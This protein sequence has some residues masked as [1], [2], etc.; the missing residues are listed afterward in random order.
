MALLTVSLA[1][2][3]NLGPFLAA[4]EG[5]ATGAVRTVLR[6]QGNKARNHLRKQIRTAGLGKLDKTVRLSVGPPGQTLP[7]DL[8]A[9]VFSSS[10]IP[11]QGQPVNLLAVYAFGTTIRPTQ[12]QRLAIPT[13]LAPRSGR[14]ALSPEEAG[15]GRFVLLPNRGGR[16]ARLVF[17][18]DRQRVAYWLVPEV[19]VRP[20]LR[21][22]DAAKAGLQ[23]MDQL[24]AVELD[25]RLRAAGISESTLEAL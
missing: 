7:A 2:G 8:E 15:R 24:L 4:L 23:G 3:G 18:D 5:A 14:R 21:L 19:R 1:L 12:G 17:R 10:R 22:Q 13:A 25:R 16:G 20:Q 6:R 9:H 11:R